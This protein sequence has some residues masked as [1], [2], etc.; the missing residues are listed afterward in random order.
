MFSNLHRSHKTAVDSSYPKCPTVRQCGAAKFDGKLFLTLDNNIL[1]SSPM[2]PHCCC[3]SY[4]GH[5]CWWRLS[6][7]LGSRSG[8]CGL[9]T[10]G[11]SSGDLNGGQFVSIMW[12][13]CLQRTLKG[14]QV[15]S[16]YSLAL[17]LMT[18]MMWRAAASSKDLSVSTIRITF[19]Y[20]LLFTS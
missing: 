17:M 16:F 10:T 6:S 11:V 12:I 5:A 9:W 13:V 8:D 18:L 19:V 2:F 15:H 20:F 3:P 4:R 14:S 7:S 1:L